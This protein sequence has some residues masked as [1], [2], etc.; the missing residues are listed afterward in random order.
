M[1]LPFPDSPVKGENI[2]TSI[3]RIEQNLEYLDGQVSLTSFYVKYLTSEALDQNGTI[4]VRGIGFQPTACIVF[5]S[6]STG[7]SVSWGMCDSDSSGD[8][9]NQA[10]NYETYDGTVASINAQVFYLSQASGVSTRAAVGDFVSDGLDLTW[11]AAGS[12]SG[13]A[14]LNII[15]LK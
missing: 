5:A 10:C 4:Q 6:E 11:V 8:P 13:N 12:P 2:A 1:A 9:D 7:N 3:S 15:C 14:L